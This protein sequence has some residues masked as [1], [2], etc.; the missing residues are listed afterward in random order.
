L[1]IPPKDLPKI[2]KN[3]TLLVGPGVN[4]FKKEISRIL[5]DKVLFLS[6][7]ICY[8]SGEAVA[9]IG[10]RKLLAGEVE[11]AESL[12][13]LYVRESDAQL[14]SFKAKS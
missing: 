10:I 4:V 3:K 9:R 1:A 7:E 11:N 2:I 13:P 12:E 5:K 6:E 14:K 8:I